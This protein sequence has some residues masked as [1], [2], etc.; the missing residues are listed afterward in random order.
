MFVHTLQPLHNFLTEL[1]TFMPRT[2]SLMLFCISIVGRCIVLD[3]GI[4]LDRE[5]A[6]NVESGD[7]NVV[8]GVDRRG[9]VHALRR[10]ARAYM[11]VVGVWSRRGRIGRELLQDFPE[12]WMADPI[13]C[14]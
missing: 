7:A 14:F 12:I 4:V 1:L 13:D 9:M 3:M 5:E 6:H 11:L 10:S 2:C 8:I